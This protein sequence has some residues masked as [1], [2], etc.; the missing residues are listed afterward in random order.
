MASPTGYLEILSAAL[1]L[2]P[3]ICT[4]L[5]LK[6]SVFS[7]RFLNLG[8]GIPSRERSPNILSSGLWSTAIVR[9]LHPK[10]KCFAFSRASLTARGL[11]QQG[12]SVIL[13]ER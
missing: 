10:T 9:S 4:S 13:L 8:L 11:P 3:G 2:M 12:D 6:R 7:L 5:N 1:F